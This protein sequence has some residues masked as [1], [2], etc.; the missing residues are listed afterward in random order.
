LD[1][2]LDEVMSQPLIEKS[3]EDLANE[4]TESFAYFEEQSMLGEISL[5]D[6]S[7]VLMSLLR[8]FK[9]IKTQL[10]QYSL[11][12]A[13]K[14]TQGTSFTILERSLCVYMRG[15]LEPSRKFTTI[16]VTCAWLFLYLG[17]S[18]WSDLIQ[19]L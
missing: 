14:R 9:P 18:K 11:F 17:P 3:F 2:L 15:I 13:S 4:L 16:H 5:A 10:E 6:R 7:Q 1:F 12:D 8:A 19:Q